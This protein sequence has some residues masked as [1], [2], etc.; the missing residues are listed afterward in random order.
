MSPTAHRLLKQFT[1][2]LSKITPI[3][4]W[5]N[6][7]KIIAVRQPVMDR[8]LKPTGPPRHHPARYASPV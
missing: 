1:S 8:K 2:G 3:F 4:Q 5:R 7:G 6:K